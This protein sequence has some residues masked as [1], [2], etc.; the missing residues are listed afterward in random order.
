LK[1]AVQCTSAGLAHL[2]RDLSDDFD[3]SIKQGTSLT[4]IIRQK[5]NSADA[6]VVQDCGRQ[7]EIP[8]IGLETQG[9]IGLDGIPSPASCSS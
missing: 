7:A 2:R 1:K 6:E 3:T 8:A 9:M 5:T 4:G